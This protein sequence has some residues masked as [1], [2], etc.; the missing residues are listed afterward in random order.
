[1]VT[2]QG[3]NDGHNESRSSLE[4]YPQMLQDIVTRELAGLARDVAPYMATE[5]RTLMEEKSGGKELK[6]KMKETM[7]LVKNRNY[8]MA[9]T[10][11]LAIH[12]NYASFAAAYNAA[13][14]YEVLGDAPAAAA[15]MAN[16]YNKTGNPSAHTAL[17]RLTRDIQQQTL[18]A[19]EYN[20]SQGQRD[21]VIVH[22]V[23][24]IHR[25]LPQGAKLWIINNS[26]SEKSLADSIV[27][28]IISGLVKNGVTVVDRENSKLVEAEQKFQM[29]GSVSDADFVGIANAAGAN[30]LAVVSVA[31]TS[32]L[33]RL[34]VRVLDIEKRTYL[35]QS[36]AGDKWKL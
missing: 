4:S 14:M 25:I 6:A 19:G 10:E 24:E 33:R 17:N 11:F 13:I 21:R 7:G 35:L 20:T 2:K 36:D 32:S 26:T 5:T 3:K 31:G 30:L 18:L 34:Q 12:E 23:G 9:L 16:V 27:D 22:A 8:S 1:M 28:G 15:L 29:S